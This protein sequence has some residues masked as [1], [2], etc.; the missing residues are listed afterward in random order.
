VPLSGISHTN[1]QEIVPKKLC[2]GHIVSLCFRILSCGTHIACYH[3]ERVEEMDKVRIRPEWQDTGDENIVWMIV[4]NNG[5]RLLLQADLGLPLNP[6]CV[7]T[8]EMVDFCE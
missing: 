2:S 5:G 6:Q 4:E 3:G 7:V 8:R 1:A